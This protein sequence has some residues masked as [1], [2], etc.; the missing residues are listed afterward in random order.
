MEE[1]MNNNT[2]EK[3][4][5]AGEP[6]NKSLSNN[7]EKQPNKQAIICSHVGYNKFGFSTIPVV[8][9]GKKPADSTWKKHQNELPSIEWCLGWDKHPRNFGI[10]TGGIS[11]I[12]VLD[13]DGD[14]GRNTHQELEKRLGKLPETPTVTTGRGEHRYFKM[15]RNPRYPIRNLAGKTKSGEIMKGIDMRA[16]GGYV[17][18]PPSTHE[19]GHVYEWSI[20]L[21]EVELAE[22]PEKWLDFLYGEKAHTD[23]PQEFSLAYVQKAVEDEFSALSAAQEGAR[24]LQLNK[25]SF[26]LAQLVSTGHVNESELEQK[27]LSTALGL[28]LERSEA[29]KTIRSGMD[30]GR[31][32]PRT[33]GAEGFSSFSDFSDPLPLKREFIPASDFPLDSLP[34][35]LRDATVAINDKIQAPIGLCAQ[36]VLAATNLAVQGFADVVLPMGQIKPISCYFSTIGSS[37]ERKSAADE[38]AIFPVRR[39][40]EDLHEANKAKRKEYKIQHRTWQ[41]EY[42][43]ICNNKK[44]CQEEVAQSLRDLG[45]EPP[46]PMESSLTCNEPTYEGL[47]KKLLLGQP[48]IGLFSAEGGRFLGGHA[49][50][51]DNRLKTAA[52]LSELWDGTPIDRVRAE[53]GSIRIYGKR[54]C[55]HL[56]MQPDISMLLFQDD[57]LKEQG[58]LSRILPSYPKSTMGMRPYKDASLQSSLDLNKYQDRIYELFRTELP[59]K[60]E[61]YNELEPRK[62][63][64][65]KGARIRWIDFVN[66]IE[67]RLVSE[68]KEISGFANKAPEHAARIA[69]TFS[70]V[71][72]LDCIG[73]S[74]EHMIS[75]I[76]LARY[77]M[78]ELMR[79]FEYSIINKDILLAETLLDWINNKWSEKYISLPDIYQFG[80]NMIRDSE[81][82][83][84]LVKILKE[85]GHLKESGRREVKGKV[86]SKTWEIVESEG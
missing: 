41:I 3:D 12:A 37:G 74:E 30:A 67:K 47:V 38:E 69:A 26:A 10:V 42:R 13:I 16:E 50:S 53:D 65:S 9:R 35:L 52:G 70:L 24:N 61:T 72:K 46:P 77:Y 73:I 59:I 58:L 78:S 64:F 80:P 1:T 49:M 79:I 39:R 11:G 44:L 60:D 28:G 82:A 34:K 63:K 85:H 15:P 56:M 6:L 22:M 8:R 20:P 29:E 45:S 27:L 25:S 43:K 33:Q 55:S 31:A 48:S 4:P 62:L 76:E 19:N 17:V 71:E 14:G 57:V 51:G 75:G 36:S 23:E 7:K 83:K 40:E 18:A 66:E 2:K 81:T 86:R 32:K 5:L 54:V 84:I 68:Y 21:L